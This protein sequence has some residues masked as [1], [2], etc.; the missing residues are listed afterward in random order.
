ME[1]WI[2][3]HYSGR[4]GDVPGARHVYLAEA[5]VK[6]GHRVLL[7]YASNHH[8]RMRRLEEHRLGRIEEDEASGVRY[9]AI[10]VLDYEGNGVGRLKNLLAF[11]SSSSVFTGLARSGEVGTPD[12][13]L[14]SSPTPFVFL[15][16]QAISRRCGGKI[17]FEVRDLW[18]ESLVDVMGKSQWHPVVLM[19]RLIVHHA[20]RRSDAVTSLLP[21]SR[22]YLEERS[23]GKRV[24]IFPNGL[25]HLQR[26]SGGGERL[27]PS[28]VR[29]SIEEWRAKGK[30]LIGYAG[31]M[32][33]PNGL[34][35]LLG[36]KDEGEGEMPFQILLV[37]D[38]PMRKEL[39]DRAES[40]GLDYLTFLPRIPRESVHLF[41]GEMDVN[42]ACALPLSIYRYGISFN[43]IFDYM[44]VG[45]PTLFAGY[46]EKNPVALSGGGLVVPPQNPVA[47]RS[48]I[49]TLMEMPSEDLDKMGSLAKCYVER[50]HNWDKIG[51]EYGKFLEAVAKA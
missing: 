24:G 22:E 19:F 47:L 23:S 3:N 42:V 18:P 9:L 26:E 27:V 15:L 13:I 30:F 5:L 2:L 34:D 31:S 16:A 6:M 11:S 7:A 29:R 41:L 40:S 1:I 50:N 21:A 49:G 36:L 12:I 38:G 20:Y 39:E 44:V 10:G 43:K 32:G 28:V 14:A 33:P 51:R 8:H 37:G 48:A 17:V 46:A 4:P 25:G 35:L 45:R